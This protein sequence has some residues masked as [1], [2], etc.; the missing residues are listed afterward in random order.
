MLAF[1]MCVEPLA[2]EVAVPLL[3]TIVRTK[4]AAPSTV[5]APTI[6]KETDVEEA[7][8]LPW[9]VVVHNDPVNL[10]SYVTMVFQRVFG[11]PRDKAERHMLEV[12][13][14]GRSILWS[15]MRERAE[16]YVQQ[17]HGYLLLATIEKVS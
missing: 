6:E 16:L 7:L 11:Y 3:S 17:L 15:G 1:F 4:S 9:H 2:I 13:Q 14:K 8:D 5:G 12:H 10:M